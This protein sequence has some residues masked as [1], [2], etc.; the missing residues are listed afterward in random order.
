MK[1]QFKFQR[2]IPGVT[3][4]N[5][6]KEIFQLVHDLKLSPPNV[7]TLFYQS[8]FALDK[9]ISVVDDFLEPYYAQ[10]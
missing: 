2:A 8:G 4:I 3:L 6:N 9:A 5:A 10:N 7:K 1:R